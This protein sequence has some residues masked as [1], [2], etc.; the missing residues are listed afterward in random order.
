MTSTLTSAQQPQRPPCCGIADLA[1]F[2]WFEDRRYDD[3]PPTADE[4]A[5]LT[6][7][8]TRDAYIMRATLLVEDM[9]VAGWA[10]A[11][12][13]ALRAELD[14]AQRAV[15]FH[16]QLG[17]KAA[18]EVQDLR[19]QLATLTQERDAAR[20]ALRALL[21]L[22]VLKAAWEQAR[23]GSALDQACDQASRILHLPDGRP[24]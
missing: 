20:D 22:A 13:V 14:L 12:D 24:L 8:P 18:F 9:R 7:T 17:Q 6:G 3:Q 2:L 23:E 16:T 21:K 15:T 11:A 19:A 5:S 1:A 4:W 10:P